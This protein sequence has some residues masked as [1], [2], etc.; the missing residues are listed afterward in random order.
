MSYNV[1]KEKKNAE[2]SAIFKIYIMEGITTKL[3]HSREEKRV[4]MILTTTVPFNPHQL[5]VGQTAVGLSTVQVKNWA[6]TGL[7]NRWSQSLRW[8]M[9]VKASGILSPSEQKSS[10]TASG[11]S[12]AQL[13]ATDNQTQSFPNTILYIK[14]HILCKICFT[15]IF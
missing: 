5:L 11:R 9:S 12:S 8:L 13:R 4:Y 15:N 2:V 1:L 6:L 7:S 10:S 3:K 14:G